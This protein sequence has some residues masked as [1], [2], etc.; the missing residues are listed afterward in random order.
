MEA[1][2]EF[3][4][5]RIYE[6]TC[7]NESAALHFDTIHGVKGEMYTAREKMKKDNACFRKLPHAYV[8]ITRATD[9][10]SL[11]FNSIRFSA[12]HK[13]YFEGKNN[14]WEIVYL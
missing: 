2:S 14:G 5:N 9:F 10:F 8:A 7:G 3:Q 11:S 12:D 4:E 6:Y 13:A 1:S